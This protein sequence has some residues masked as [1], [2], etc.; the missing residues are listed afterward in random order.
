VYVDSGSTDDSIEIAHSYGVNVHELDQSLPFSAARARDEGVTRLLEAYPATTLLMF[1]DGDCELNVR[2]PAM[3]VE[4]LDQHPDVGVVAGRRRERHP[5]KSSYNRLCD[6][7][8]DTP[9]GEAAAVGGDFVVRVDAYRQVGGFDRTVPAGEEPEL[10]GRLRAAGWRVVRLDHEMTLHDAAITHFHQWW[11]RHIR[12]GYGGYDVERRFRLGIFDRILR[13]AIVWAVVLPV[14]AVVGAL[15]I[16]R[17]IGWPAA[18]MIIAAAT[19][20]WCAQAARIAMR[21]RR[22]GRRWRECLEFGWFTMIAKVPILLGA[23]K[24]AWR[25]VRGEPNRIVEYKLP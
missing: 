23:G 14:S 11:K 25:H 18:V 15:V 12:T 9:I 17:F 20:L 7:E 24:A 3:A 10:C 8:W 19:L 6:I 16:S 13:S 4:F 21:V 5:E 22:A 1:I 2:W